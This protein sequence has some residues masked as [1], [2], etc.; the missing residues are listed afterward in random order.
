MKTLEKQLDDKA[1]AKEKAS[2]EQDKENQRLQSELQKLQTKSDKV[3]ETAQS[4]FE[5]V[6]LSHHS[7]TQEFP[8]E[9]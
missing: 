8:R 1:E 2:N 6:P 3:L 5:Q 7:G 4:R 9:N